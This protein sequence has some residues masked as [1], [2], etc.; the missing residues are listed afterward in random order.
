MATH[1][2]HSSQSCNRS[3][4]TKNLFSRTKRKMETELEGGDMMLNMGS[5]CVCERG[6]DSW[7]CN[8]GFCVR[9]RER[10]HVCVCERE[11]ERE[12]ERDFV[13]GFAWKWVMVWVVC[14]SGA[15]KSKNGSFC[16]YFFIFLALLYFCLLFVCEGNC[17][18]WQNI[19]IWIW[20]PMLGETFEFKLL[21]KVVLNKK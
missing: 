19:W 8:W 12:R 3:K 9:E 10:F 18:F 2:F 11:W 6:T 21:V 20:E 16:L 5:V 1:W 14:M 17:L 15:D 4:G 7:V 13:W